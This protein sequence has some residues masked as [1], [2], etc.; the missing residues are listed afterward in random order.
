MLYKL[1]KQFYIFEEGLFYNYQG[2]RQNIYI[3][4]QKYK[5]KD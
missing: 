4:I 2:E 1:I 3:K 5:Y